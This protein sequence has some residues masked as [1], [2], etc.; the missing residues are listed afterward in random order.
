[1]TDQNTEKFLGTQEQPATPPTQDEKTM[2]MLSH[3]LAI[4]F[5]ILAPLIIYLVKKDESDFVK[6]NAAES[7]NFQITSIIVWI[8]GFITMI[9]LV[10][11]LILALWG[12]VSLILIV[13]A[14][15]R[16]SEGK[17]YRYPINIRLIK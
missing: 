2:G 6:K 4:I 17:I 15:I 12:L 10:G 3:L 7:L 5:P 1:M 14:T 8:V 11:F 13:V 9:I 16:S